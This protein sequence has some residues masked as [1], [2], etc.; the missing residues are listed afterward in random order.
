MSLPGVT[1]TSPPIPPVISPEDEAIKVSGSPD[2]AS[3]YGRHTLTSVVNGQISDRAF[4]ILCLIECLSW[5][6]PVELTYAGIANAVKCSRRDI[7]RQVKALEDLGLL[8]VRRA[9]N[10]SSEYSVPG[11]TGVKRGKPRPAPQPASQISAVQEPVRCPRCG[12]KCRQLL[13]YGWCR[14]CAWQ[15]RVEQVVDDRLRRVEKTS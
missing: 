12:G 10:S 9:N 2:G 5:A 14:A 1:P 11:V 4:R 13:R 7:I 3:L 8:R 15:I 6:V